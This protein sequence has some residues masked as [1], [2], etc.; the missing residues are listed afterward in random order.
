MSLLASTGSAGALSVY[1]SSGP[2]PA[3]CPII[4]KGEPGSTISMYSMNDEYIGNCIVPFYSDYCVFSLS[5]KYADGVYRVTDGKT[6]LFVS[7]SKN[8][9]CLNCFI[10]DRP[11]PRGVENP[12][13]PNQFCNVSSP[14]AWGTRPLAGIV[15][16]PASITL[17]QNQMYVFRAYGFDA[18]NNTVSITPVWRSSNQQAGTINEHGAFTAKSSGTT[19]ITAEYSG[20]SANASAEVIIVARPDYEK[21]LSLNA[22]GSAMLGDTL[23][24]R[25]TKLDGTPFAGRTVTIITPTKTVTL[26]AMTDDEGRLLFKAPEPGVYLYEVQGYS[27]EKTVSTF[28]EAWPPAECQPCANA[29]CPNQTTQTTECPVQA[30]QP[31]TSRIT[32]YFASMGGYAPAVIVV[33]IL[34]AFVFGYLLFVRYRGAKKEEEQMQT[35]PFSPEKGEETKIWTVADFETPRVPARVRPKTLAAPASKKTEKERKRKKSK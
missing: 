20:F 3:D 9:P 32:A 24:A 1:A 25:V 31:I 13:N 18:N 28:V 6:H 35:E 23:S 10:D 5:G 4:V 29:T 17:G 27:F 26:N 21:I 15:V 22:P 34:L 2:Y 30:Q 8:A 16:S 11:Y 19:A 14:W 7:F 12:S 33:I